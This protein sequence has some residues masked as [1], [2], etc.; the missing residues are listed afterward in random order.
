MPDQ[1][2]LS[3]W[4]RGFTEDNMLR[5]Y[6]KVLERFPFSK[7]APGLTLRVYAIEFAEPPALERRFEAD[8]DLEEVLRSAEEFRNPDCAY[9]LDAK[10]DLW[11]HE[12]DWRLGPSPVA[13]TCFGPEFP[14]EYGEQLRVDAGAEALFLPDSE[15]PMGFR[16]VE[17]NIRSL[18][19]LN[20]DL[21]SA[22][23]VE[24]LLLWSESGE[25]LAERLEA[26][27]E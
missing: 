9:M 27:L 24:K 11:Q 2:Y 20:Q 6:Q 13:I 3:V 12:G 16:A 8:A 19:H 22:L 17:S 23:P 18:L 1:V 14:S 21:R 7:L 25:N 5:H 15:A 4:L 10:W 26:M